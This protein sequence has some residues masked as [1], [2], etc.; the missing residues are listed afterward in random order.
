MK[1]MTVLGTRPEIIRLACVLPLLDETV[2]HT[3]VHTGQNYDYELNEVFFQELGLRAPDRFLSARVS[4][5]G[6]LMGDVLVQTEALIDEL[7]PDAFLVL[8]DTNS[9]V[10]ALIA[11]RK[12]VT[13]FHMEAGNRC[14]D[15]N[16]PEETNRRLVDHVS[17]INLCYTEHARR[18]LLAEGK[19]PRTLYVTGS[20]MY[21]VLT[22][23]S[24]QI[25]GSSAVDSHGLVKDRYLLVSLH[26]EENVDKPAR[27]LQLLESISGTAR[28]LSLPCLVSVHPRTAKHLIDL[29][30][31]LLELLTL[32]KP[33]GFHDYNRLQKDAYAVISDSGTISEES[34]I[35]GFAGVTPRISIERPEA[36]DSGT[37]TLAGSSV[38]EMMAAI[39]HSRRVVL[40]GLAIPPEEYRVP[41]FSHRVLN[42]ILSLTPVRAQWDGVRR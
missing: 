41:D 14:W 18:N 24:D 37:I 31:E 21:E 15:L 2:D 39:A 25:L 13:V 29:P 22:K 28:A 1:V 30:K 36:L 40:S 5:P 20:P 19:H 33:L 23:F 27:L 17:D 4:S 34:S 26:R 38:Q 9:C 35:L 8:G 16:V 6:A 12:G 10:A 42:S 32:S 7:C 11:R 3:L